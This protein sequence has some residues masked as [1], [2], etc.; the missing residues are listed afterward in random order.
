[1]QKL[2]L[3]LFVVALGVA[4]SGCAGCY[5]PMEYTHTYVVDRQ[6]TLIEDTTP[7][8]TIIGNCGR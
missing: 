1:M 6:C 8:C 5:K 2:A 7:R 3:A 4:L